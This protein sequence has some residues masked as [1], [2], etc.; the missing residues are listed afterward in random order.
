MEQSLAPRRNIAR[1][2][3]LSLQQQGSDMVISYLRMAAAAVTG[4]RLDNRKAAI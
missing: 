1:P 4:T 2:A 3:P